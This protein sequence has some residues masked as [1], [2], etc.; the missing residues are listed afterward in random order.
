MSYNLNFV[1]P[2]RRAEIKRRI[3]ALETF[4]ASGGGRILA[5]QL[6]AEIGVGV[7][8]FYQLAKV[9]RQRKD[10]SALS[11][12]RKPIS[13]RNRLSD[14]QR[15]MITEALRQ[16]PDATHEDVSRLAT[17][18]GQRRGVEMPVFSTIRQVVRKQLRARLPSTSPAWGVDLI[19]EHC[20]INVGVIGPDGGA[21]M[22]IA[23]I[24]T[25]VGDARARSVALSREIPTASTAAHVIQEVLQKALIAEGGAGR[26]AVY[27]DPLF[28]S[29]WDALNA[30]LHKANIETVGTRRS[31]VRRP[32]AT[33][34]LLGPKVAAISLHPRMTNRTF[35]D[36]PARLMRGAQAVELDQAEEFV[37]A[38]LIDDTAPLR[39]GGPSGAA[40]TR[41]MAELANIASSSSD[42]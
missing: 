2:H 31:T 4:L 13:V 15:Q 5:E 11:G 33:T 8:L 36:R 14:D 7:T 19:V 9:W 12:A 42:E 26:T 30:A 41:L 25:S 23:T 20:A 6:S 37:W 40:M 10:P 17:E 24:C 18:I 28:G 16:L 1:P 3:E 39:L 22:P 27:L 35:I 21:Y 32:D 29:D 38:R 34:S